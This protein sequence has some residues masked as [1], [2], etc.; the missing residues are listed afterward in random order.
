MT[1]RAAGNTRTFPNNSALSAGT[2]VKM[3]AGYLVAAGAGD[4]ELGILESTVLATDT[5]ASVRLPAN[6]ESVRAIVAGAVTQ[7]ADIYRAG[8]G[9]LSAT[10]NGLRWGVSLEAAS[11]NGSQIEVLRLPADAQELLVEDHTADDTLTAAEMYGSV[12]TTNGATGTV[13][14]SLPAAVVGMNSMFRVGAAFELRIDPNGT[15]KVSLPSTGVPGAAGKYLSADANG[16]T[17][18]L[19][20][21]KAGEWSVFGHTGTWTA[22]A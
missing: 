4:D 10:P 11:G 20:C 12:H 22:E 7:Y 16:E 17:V 15:E 1:I 5:S 19:V 14:L 3:S 8:S 18:R 9:K 21:T 6:N 2:R 13:V